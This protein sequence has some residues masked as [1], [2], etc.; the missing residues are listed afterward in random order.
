MTKRTA[1]FSR[2]STSERR[3]EQTHR[4]RQAEPQ[5]RSTRPTADRRSASWRQLVAVAALAMAYAVAI[6]AANVLT[7]GLGLVPSGFGLL[8]TAGTYTAGLALALRDTLHDHG[9]PYVVLVALAVGVVCSV[10]TADPRISFASGIAAAGGELIDLA[11]YRP[12]RRHSR[13]AAIAASGVAGAFVDSVGF[14]V[15]AGFPVTASAVGGQL[16][17]K[18]VWVTGA[19][20]L[21]IELVTR[22]VSRQRQLTGHP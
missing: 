20:V 22:A 14:L 9:G 10:Y 12:L 15:L 17:V 2:P 4:Q 21:F 11:V 16:L 3:A 19:Y 7:T 5:A 8:V 18:A 1:R 6:A 13:P